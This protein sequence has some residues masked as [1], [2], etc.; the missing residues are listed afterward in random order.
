M[1]SAWLRGRARGPSHPSASCETTMCI[2]PSRIAS[3]STPASARTAAP[4]AATSFD[5]WAASHLRAPWRR[6]AS[7]S[8]CDVA[9]GTGG[10]GSAIGVPAAAAMRSAIVGDGAG[11]AGCARTP[12]SAMTAAGANTHAAAQNMTP[13]T[14]QNVRGADLADERRRA[15]SDLETPTMTGGTQPGPARF[16][17]FQVSCITYHVVDRRRSSDDDL[18]LMP[19]T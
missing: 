7:I 19:D 18:N 9:S 16:A 3:R 6:L 8:S 5:R 11:L 10:S 13:G 17:Q 14:R 2:I 1:P 15:A 4:V 12:T